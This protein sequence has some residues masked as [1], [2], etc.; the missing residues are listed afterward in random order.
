MT[1]LNRRLREKRQGYRPRSSIILIYAFLGPPVGSLLFLLGV[2]LFSLQDEINYGVLADPSVL[3]V[4][5]G[6]GAFLLFFIF[7]IPFSYMF[8]FVQA[9][10]TGVV[11]SGLHNKNGKAG[12]LA[13]FLTPLGI[14]AGA[15]AVFGFGFE[16]GQG[17]AAA[18]AA[19]GV[20][21]S[22]ILRFLFRGAFENN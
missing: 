15:Y 22:L 1:I 9:L 10:L 8:G 6:I 11:L 13:A 20:L 17:F 12:Y 7:T 16:F 14:S 21:T 3:G 19:I 4:L 2:F 5:K 18:I